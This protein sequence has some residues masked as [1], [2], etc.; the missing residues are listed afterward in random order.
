MSKA[1]RKKNLKEKKPERKNKD[2]NRIE[3]IQF[4]A[5]KTIIVYIYIESI[6]FSLLFEDDS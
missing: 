6:L 2:I 1:N 3:R 4:P 5:I